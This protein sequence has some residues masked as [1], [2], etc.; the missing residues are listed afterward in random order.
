MAR[1]TESIFL[2]LF[3]QYLSEMWQSRAGD[4]ANGGGATPLHPQMP[5]PMVPTWDTP[6]NGEG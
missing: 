2:F 6:H 3:I 5:V 1:H 4:G